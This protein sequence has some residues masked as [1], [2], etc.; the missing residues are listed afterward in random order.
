MNPLGRTGFPLTDP[1]VTRQPD[2]AQ[3]GL[4]S[5]IG[6]I[7][8]IAQATHTCRLFIATPLAPYSTTHQ[9]KTMT[10]FIVNAAGERVSAV[11]P[12]AEY[13]ALLEAAAAEDETAFLL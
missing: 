6:L 8:K 10:Q 11:I 3:V 9:E 13:E 5:S 12:I 2:C 1:K 7:P 4:L